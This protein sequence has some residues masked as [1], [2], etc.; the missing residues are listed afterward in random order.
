MKK[1][2][3]VLSLANVA[4]SFACTTIIVGKNATTDGS[5]LVARNDDGGS[6]NSPS[7][8]VYHQP[9]AK[10]Y[11]FS[12]VEENKYS[13]QLP[14]N[15]MGYTGMPDWGTRNTPGGGTFEEVGFNDAGV[16]ISATETIFSNPQ[17]LKV[18]PYLD[19]S[20]VVEEAIPSILLPQIKSARQGVEMLGK[21]IETTGS[22]EGFGVV[23][24]IVKKRGIWKMPV[25][26]SG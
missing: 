23:L 7:H 8:L 21:I 26:I 17:T 15:L 1:I 12:S 14:D 16:G 4:S 20:G 24:L 18:D 22:G 10:G 19:E 11:L 9:R 3:L 2:V 6:A 13:Y 5:I 25:G